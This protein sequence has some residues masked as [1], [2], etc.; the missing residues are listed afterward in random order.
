MIPDGRPSLNGAGTPGVDDDCEPEDELAAVLDA[1]LAEVEAGRPVNPEDWVRRHPAVAGRLRAC[2]RSLH[3]VEAAAEA[4]DVA[5]A[6]VGAGRDGLRSGSEPSAGDADP[7]A[8]RIGDFRVVREIGR[9]GMGVVYEAV[10]GSLG[11][12]VALK[13]LPLAAA[14]DPRQIARFRV[15]AQA[16][17]QL[18]H[19]HI[20]P[21]YSV[22][23]QGGIHYYA[24]QLIDGP[25]LAQLIAG[26]RR[27]DEVDATGVESTS[28]APVASREGEP[29]QVGWVQ[30]TGS[31]GENPVGCTHPTRPP[32]TPSSWALNPTSTRDR[33]F[34]REAARLGREAAE[35]LEHAHEQGVLHR[36]IKPSNLMVD[37][38]GHLWV[39]DFGLARF[40]GE[41]SLTAPGDLL[42]TL[43][44]MSPE[45]ATADHAVVDE[46]TDVYSLGATLYELVALQPVFAGSDRQELLRRIAQDEPR[47]PRAI[48]PAVPRDLETIILKAM[49]KE[50]AARYATAQQLADDLG[51]FLDDRPILA[52]R[53]GPLE[54]SARWARRYASA[55]VVAVPLLAA[56][57]VALGIAFGMVVSKQA[58][59]K[60]ANERYQQA[61]ADARRQ[62]D[63]ARI[64]VEDLYT[65]TADRLRK[66]P[67]LHR[68][69]REFLSKAMLY[70]QKF[71]ME[72][73]DEPALR[74]DAGIATFRVGDIQRMLGQ[75]ADAEEAYRK[76]IK[77]FEEIP[78]TAP[79]FSART[80]VLE[81]LGRSYGQLGQLLAES[82]R[83]A[84]ARPVLERAVDLTRALAVEVTDPSPEGR[85]RLAMVHHREG[86]LLRLL[87]RNEEAEAAY[88][89]AIEMAAGV[90]GEEGW[91]LRA[92]VR[93]NLGQL[94]STTSRRD[95]AEAV[96]R[97]AA[98]LYESMLKSDPEV[99]VYRQELARALDRRGV[100]AAGKP[101]GYAEAEGLIRRAL[102]ID[103]KLV[104]QSP[105]VPSFCQDRALT[106]T[107]L[108]DVVLA[109]GPP[110]RPRRSTGNRSRRSRR[111]PARSS[112]R[113][114]T[115]G[116]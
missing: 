93:G 63:E 58:E 52:R 65:Q 6:G 34:F 81:W 39:T 11:R 57:V 72:L 73:D 114:R 9:G 32:S 96:F 7:D 80:R 108:A 103:E 92:G 74:V 45:Q 106:R 110:A 27:G 113:R 55:L 83:M 60:A 77:V 61:H 13:V 91:E 98:E 111:C 25:T 56:A 104:A 75:P 49:S 70:Y 115:C 12:R 23:C 30:P 94:L 78:W 54:R 102:E 44:Y 71:S 15:E 22:G 69:R 20:V 82:N 3:L 47:R 42:G 87:E 8:P 19:P 89:K 17:S 101:G 26:L 24:M 14:I 100:L 86:V 62:R 112:S 68:L 33:S 38:R 59:L 116:G 16:A 95:E 35:A 10:E 67:S 28:K 5:P 37:G 46:R 43:R 48:E 99:P 51:R 76:A 88:R 21:V 90:R 53:P 85:A 66:L 40:Q 107:D 18:N 97:E 79:G 109:A 64:A 29:D 50:P 105:D 41:A 1:Y 31:P 84:E 4:L 36:D 2:L